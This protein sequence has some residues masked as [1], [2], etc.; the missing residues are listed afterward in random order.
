MQWT[1]QQFTLDDSGYATGTFTFAHGLTDVTAADLTSFSLSATFVGNVLGQVTT[2]TFVYG[3][4]DVM[5]FSLTPSD[6]TPTHFSLDTFRVVGGNPTLG[7]VG[8]VVATYPL[9]PDP[10]IG[11]F[12]GKGDVVG[13][14]IL[15]DPVDAPEPLSLA[16]VPI[17]GALLFKLR[18]YRHNSD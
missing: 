1:G 17:G 4:A 9:S 10:F 2:G 16:L 14:V 13:N 7:H 12:S 11:W 3:L 8:F 5:D 18:A 15:T 6:P